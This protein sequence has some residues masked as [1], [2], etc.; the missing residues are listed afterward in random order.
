[1]KRIW[2]FALCLL[3]A[4]MFAAGDCGAQAKK[5]IIFGNMADLTG[6]Y[7]AMSKDQVDAMEM[8]V[9]EI[10]AAG[11]LL[12]RKIKM[13][14]EDTQTS[15]A[16]TTRKLERLVSEEKA[17]FLFSPVTSAST[18][19]I[20]PLAEK[21]DR[22]LMVSMSQSIKITTTD[23]NKYTF[24]TCAN[25]SIT[26]VYLVDWMMKNLGKK[27]YMLNVDYAWGRS[28]S[29]MYNKFLKE[30]GANIVGE[31]FFP[32]GT[33]DF[34]PYFG[35]IKAAQPQILFVTCAGNDAISVLT[36]LDQYGLKKTMAITGDGS[37]VASDVL[38]AVGKSADGVIT[39][40]Y[41]ADSLDTPAHKKWAASY[42]KLYKR[43]PS[44]F[45]VSS[46]EAVMWLAQAIRK[47]GTTESKK[48][49]SALEGS[50]Y[51]GPL[52]EKK[53]D[54]N[55]HQTSLKIYMIKIENGKPKIFAT[56]N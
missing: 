12:G 38:P 1:M 39:A 54:P 30:K 21:Y 35:K 25:P 41:Y 50:T 44:K 8:A 36:Q 48:V 51:T 47:A 13:V 2:V 33:K 42:K 15:V 23:K 46:Y 32:L 27:V 45:A 18:L 10:N 56:A 28:T 3:V 55:S 43:E 14:T 19:A 37:L 24:R 29:E 34:A 40:D 16:M 22:I 26:G 4:G 7:A 5:P 31:T 6:T 9:N 49:I 52:G 20:M 11:G 53:M 17:D